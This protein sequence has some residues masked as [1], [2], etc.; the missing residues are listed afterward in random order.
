MA[1]LWRDAVIRSH[2]MPWHADP[3]DER[4]GIKGHDAIPA[5][6]AGFA[7]YVAHG[8]EER[9]EDH[10]KNDDFDEDLYGSSAPE[11]THE[12]ERHNEEHGE[13]PES[14]YERHDEEYQRAV[15]DKRAAES[16][17]HE[18]YRL[19]EFVGSH[20]LN[21]DWWK[22]HGHLTQV[23]L[24]GP[25]YATQSHVHPMH[26]DRYRAAPDDHSWYRQQNGSRS[27][28]YFNREYLADKHPMFVTHEGRLHV[29]DGH[30][31]VAAALADGRSHIAAWHYDADKHGIPE[32]DEDY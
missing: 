12:E 4:Q 16:P 14:Y 29:T 23:P 26:I 19:H 18:D 31:R 9:W 27:S 20:G 8:D 21:T 17:S 13:Y 15:D 6:K 32:Y 28:P 10:S 7:G 1:L 24:S 5:S 2:A 25:V 11:P 22:R 3:K 30:H